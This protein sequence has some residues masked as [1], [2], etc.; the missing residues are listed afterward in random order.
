MTRLLTSEDLAGYIRD[1]DPEALEHWDERDVVIRPDY[2]AHVCRYLNGTAGLEFNYL[3]A[4]SAVDYVEYFEV[5][6]HLTSMIHNHSATLKT[7]IYD[8]ETASVP[9]VLGIWHGADLQE[10]EVWD[11]MGI[12]FTGHHN[13]KRV[14]LW[15][16]FPGHPLR[17]DYLED[18]R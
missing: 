3:N 18:I 4:I 13:L 17:K 10:R 11:L 15:D 5:V 6:Y 2:V 16:G 7:R 12:E 8:R 9:S 1:A 14:L